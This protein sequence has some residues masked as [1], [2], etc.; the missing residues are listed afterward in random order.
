MFMIVYRKRY[1][2]LNVEGHQN[3]VKGEILRWPIDPC[4]L[5]KEECNLN[6]TKDDSYVERVAKNNSWNNDV[7][8]KVHEIFLINCFVFDITLVWKTV[9]STQLGNDQ[10]EA[11]LMEKNIATNC[12]K[13]TVPVLAGWTKK[14]FGH[15]ATL[16]LFRSDH[17]PKSRKEKHVFDNYSVIFVTWTTSET[18]PS[19]NP[20]TRLARTTCYC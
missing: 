2:G 6:Q 12:S 18:G 13:V 3:V 11:H 9:H 4:Y 7:C 17:R 15:Y 16:K 10:T 8:H 1:T 5:N 20:N 19:S 14:P